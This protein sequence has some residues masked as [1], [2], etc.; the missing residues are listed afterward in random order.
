M[1][2]SQLVDE[3]SKGIFTICFILR[4]GGDSG[5]PPGDPG[6]TKF[7]EASYHLG[8][9]GL[10]TRAVALVVAALQKG[11]GQFLGSILLEY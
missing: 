8:N 10:H 9:G 1:G 7:I 2:K 3:L 6:V 11:K 5:Y 4:S